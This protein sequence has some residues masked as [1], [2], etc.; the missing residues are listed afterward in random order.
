MTELTAAIKIALINASNY[1]EGFVPLDEG[2]AD[3]AAQ[4]ARE[5]WEERWGGGVDDFRYTAEPDGLRI[6][7]T[8][9]RSIG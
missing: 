4:C 8:N 5:W 6:T 7:K 9:N 1:G 2:R 3:E